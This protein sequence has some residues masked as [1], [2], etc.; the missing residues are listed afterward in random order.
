MREFIVG[1]LF[2][3]GISLFSLI[4]AG[5]GF[6]LFPLI[7]VMAVLLRIAV[8]FILAIACIWIIGKLLI[9]IFVSLKKA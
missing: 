6:L 8:V 9:W 7:I 2:I 1:L 4:I 3:V 5:L